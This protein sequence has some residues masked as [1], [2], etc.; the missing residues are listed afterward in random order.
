MPPRSK[1][2]KNSIIHSRALYSR[3]EQ[4]ALL[5][6]HHGCVNTLHWSFDGSL[7]ASG[8]DEGRCCLWYYSEQQ[9]NHLAASWDTGHTQN[10]FSAKFFPFST[11]KLA[12]CSGDSEIRL[13][14][15]TRATNI[16]DTKNDKEMQP[17]TIYR[18][19]NDRTK[20]LCMLSPEVFLSVSE[21]GTVRK[22]DTRE[23]HDCSGHDCDSHVMYDGDTSL[24]SISL[25]PQNRVEYLVAGASSN[26]LKCDLR[27]V[28]IAL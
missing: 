28:R 19:H 23:K 22:F 13:F 26:V 20:K 10:I 7:L 2:V 1:L 11:T 16:V 15:T 27:Y 12:T 3:L 18:C 6:R 17:T 25:H 8:S 4:C 21:D 14:D 24:W 5:G 9:G